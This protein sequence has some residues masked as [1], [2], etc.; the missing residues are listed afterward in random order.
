MRLEYMVRAQW[1]V[2][3]PGLCTVLAASGDHVL[4]NHLTSRYAGKRKMVIRSFRM[5]SW[6]MMN[7]VTQG[8]KQETTLLWYSSFSL[9]GASVYNVISFSVGW[10]RGCPPTPQG[11]KQQKQTYSITLMQPQVWR[12]TE[13]PTPRKLP[14]QRRRHPSPIVASA[15]LGQWAVP[16]SRPPPWTLTSWERE[17]AWDINLPFLT[18]AFSSS[19]ESPSLP[20]KPHW[21]MPQHVIILI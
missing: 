3:T 12:H 20:A 14:S 15:L 19:R 7:G 21:W 4:H 5:W 10:F 16:L 2:R 8:E 6:E 1:K 17:H 11:Q 18:K 9:L 13:K